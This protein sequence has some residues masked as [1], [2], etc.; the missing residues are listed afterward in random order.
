MREINL[1]LSSSLADEFMVKPLCL[2]LFGR[3]VASHTRSAKDVVKLT[4][5]ILGNI[6][7]RTSN[8]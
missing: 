6:G 3:H 8:G 1:K 5:Q 4:S 7:S 2:C